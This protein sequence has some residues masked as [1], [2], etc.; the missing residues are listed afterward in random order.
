MNNYNKSM[1]G[2][3]KKG[4][5][6]I[7]EAFIALLLI[8]GVLLFVINRGGFGGDDLS[9]EIYKVQVS[10]LRE[11]ETDASLREVILK[12]NLANKLPI[13]WINFT[14]E[15]GLLPVKQRIEERMPEYLECEGMLCELDTICNLDSYSEKDIYAQAVAITADKKNYQPRQLKIFCWT[16]E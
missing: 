9:N 8:M 16:R 3:N 11:I 6:R 2:K 5:I 1:V 13:P 14:D 12:E 4:W 10:V 15:T 7:V